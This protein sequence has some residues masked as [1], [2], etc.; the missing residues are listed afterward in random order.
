MLFGK[1]PVFIGLHFA[2]T[3]G[4]SIRAHAAKSLRKG[5]FFPHGVFAHANNFFSGRPMLAEMSPRQKAKFRF[6]YGH[7]VSTEVLHHFADRE[8]ALF[9]VCRDPYKRFLS[10]LKHVVR[11]QRQ[12]GET[13]DPREVY[14]SQPA[15]P[16]TNSVMKH[17]G[18]LAPDGVTDPKE[19]LLAVLRCFRFVMSTDDLNEQT[20][21]FFAAIGL[22]EMTEAKRVYRED[23]DI[24]SLSEQ[25]IRARDDLDAFVNE[26]VNDYF[27]SG[28]AARHPKG[29]INPFGFD[30]TLLNARMKALRAAAP[31]IE[32]EIETAYT[33]LFGFLDRHGRLEAAKVLI[34]AGR[35]SKRI[36]DIFDRFCRDTGRS[37]EN[38]NLPSRNLCYQAEVFLQ[39][40]QSAKARDSARRAIETDSKNPMAYYLAGRAAIEEKRFA[41]G[42]ADLERATELNPTHIASFRYLAIAYQKLGR[43]DD[44][45]KALEAAKGA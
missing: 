31:P 11:T 15:N 16:F 6:V 39:L 28:T 35:Q 40:K 26:T 21:P 41:D 42:A 14:E 20:K 17:F 37:F 24:G 7:G 9:V 33:N 8:I 5:E 34:D 30:K 22:P 44:A 13:V 4:T 19:K 12:F 38:E 1:K 18:H 25:E 27:A 43:S 36:A 3:G 29:P 10:S 23:A 2:K 32:D 45:D